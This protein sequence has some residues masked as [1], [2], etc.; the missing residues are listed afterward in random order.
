MRFETFVGQVQH[1][2]RLSSQGEALRATRAAL[3]TLGDR[4]SSDE[5]DNLAS[6]LP[7]EV[8]AYLRHQARATPGRFSLHDYYTRVADRESVDVPEAAYHARAVMSVVCEAVSPGEIDDLL[9]QLP[10][11]YHPL[12]SGSPAA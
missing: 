7:Q 3:E 5:A 4:I 2:A 6:Q 11:E 9:A 12:F 8:G 10:G 1:R